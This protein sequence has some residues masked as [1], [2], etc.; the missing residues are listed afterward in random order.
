MTSPFEL[1]SSDV[2]RAVRLRTT[3]LIILVFAATLGQPVAT[4]SA[5]AASGPVPLPPSGKTYFGTYSPPSGS[6]TQQAQMSEYTQL[7]SGLG[8]TLDVAHYYYKWGASFPTWR[9]TWHVANG[10]IPMMSWVTTTPTRSGMARR[11]R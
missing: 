11:T 7:E 3:V 4:R 6:W 9:E 10:R 1:G 8:R 5:S 2:P